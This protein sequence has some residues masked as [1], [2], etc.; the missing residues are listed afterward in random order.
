MTSETKRVSPSIR[1]TSEDR[2][3]ILTAIWRRNAIRRGVS[4]PLLDIKIEFHR[5]FKRL[6]TRRYMALLKP[7]LIVALRELGGNPGIA[8][9]IMHRLLGTQIAQRR[10]FQ[11][12]GIDQP[13]YGLSKATG[14]L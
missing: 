3:R 13:D 9:R 12:T 14:S 8:S 6:E 2:Q 4:L 10:L 5:E 1:V 7:F 11:A